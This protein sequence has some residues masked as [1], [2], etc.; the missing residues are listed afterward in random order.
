MEP[1]ELGKVRPTTLL[2]FTMTA[3]KMFFMTLGRI[4]VAHWA[5]Y[6]RL[7]CQGRLSGVPGVPPVPPTAPNPQAKL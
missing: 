7:Q 4:G 5:E 2:W 3:T 6:T 1:E